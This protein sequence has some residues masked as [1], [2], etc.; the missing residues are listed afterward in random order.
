MTHSLRACLAI[1]LIA[2]FAS[3]AVAQNAS[4]PRPDTSKMIG[5]PVRRIT[6]AAA[7]STEPLGGINSVIELPNGHVLVND[8]TRRRLLLMDTMLKKIEVVLDSVSEVANTYGTR[9]GTLIPYHGDSVLFVDPNSYAMIVLDPAGKVARVR[10]VW[11]AQ[12]LFLFTSPNGA[13]GYPATDSRGRIVYRIFA[14]PAPPKVAP[15]PGVPYFPPDPDSAFIVAMDVDTRKLDTLGSIRIPKTLNTIKQTQEGFFSFTSAINPMPSTDEW[16]VLSDGTVAFVRGRDYRVDYLHADGTWSSSPKV[17]YD[18]QRMTEE[19]KERLVDSV[20]TVNQKSAAVTYVGAMIRW[21]NTYNRPYPR[22][23]AVPEGYVPPNGFMKSWKLPE[24]LKIP[25]N[26]IYGCESGE[27]PKINP[28]PP[29]VPA[30]PIPGM[31]PGTP[32]GIPSCIPGPIM[33]S[34]G[35]VPQPPQPREVAVLPASDI[36]DFRPPFATGAVRADAEGNLWVRTIPTKPVPGGP[37]Y[38][39]IN[40]DGELADRL[41]LPPGYTVVGFGKGKVVYVSLRDAMGI[42]LARVRLR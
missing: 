26:Y 22:G 14:Q 41:Q 34:S 10:S 1:A 30:M 36:P 40:H 13:Y 31:P 11:R 9:A 15:P 7:V 28:P 18:W 35:I 4:P 19:D 32:P 29:G 24:N 21:A 5:P 39:I 16:A 38:D 6:T 37:I 12:D 33:F 17:P 3:P 27:E 2:T 25:P 42:H 20:K 23:F 8:G